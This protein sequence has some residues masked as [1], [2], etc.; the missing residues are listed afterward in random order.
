[1]CDESVINH[2][3]ETKKIE[4]T[5]NRSR[6]LFNNYILRSRNPNMNRI[7]GQWEL[8]NK[9]VKEVLAQLS[10]G[11]QCSPVFQGKISRRLAPSL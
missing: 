9:K 7:E 3:E 8:N 10:Q 4:W 2:V 1:M 6:K 11:I 5:I